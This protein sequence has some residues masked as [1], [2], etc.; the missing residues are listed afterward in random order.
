LNLTPGQ[1]REILGLSEDTF[2]H[3]RRAIPP[4]A[5]RNGYRPCFTHGDL[6]ATAL[7]KSLVDEAGIKVGALSGIAPELF[8]LCQQTAWAALERTV[9]VIEP[10]KCQLSLAVSSPLSSPN[11]PVAIH[12]PCAPIVARVRARLLAEQPAEDQQPLRFPPAAIGPAR[13]AGE[14]P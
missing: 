3:W 9:L 4:L 10:G 8:R 5:G 14:Q 6:M 1:L 2:R 7:V 11:G 13:R 12:V